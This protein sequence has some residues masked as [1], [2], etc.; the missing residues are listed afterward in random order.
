MVRIGEILKRLSGL[1]ELAAIMVVSGYG[2]CVHTAVGGWLFY[3]ALELG[4][5]AGIAAN[6]PMAHRMRTA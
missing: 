3:I 1:I 4:F 6:Y 5:Y 2:F